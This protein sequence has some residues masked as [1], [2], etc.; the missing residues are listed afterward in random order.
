MDFDE[1]W[2]D[3][4]DGYSQQR[5]KNTSADAGSDTSNDPQSKKRKKKRTHTGNATEKSQMRNNQA[6]SK[7]KKN[8]SASLHVGSLN[9]RGRSGKHPEGPSGKWGEIN[10]TLKSHKIG[11]LAIQEAHLTSEA[12]SD[13]HEMYGRRVKIHYSQ[14]ENKRKAGVA[15][16]INKDLTPHKDVTE[17][18][19]IPGRALM[20]QIPWHA[21]LI[22]TILNVYA[23]NAPTENAQFWEELQSKFENDNIEKPDVLLGDFNVVEDAIDKLPCH[24]DASHTT[25]RSALL[26]LRNDWGLQDGWRTTYPTEKNYTFI[27]PNAR[28]R[29]DRI[30]TTK[31]IL[32]TATDWKIEPSEVGTDHDMVSVRVNNPAMPFIGMGR[33]V[34]PPYLLKDKTFK[35]QVVDLTEKLGQSLEQK[36]T[37]TEEINPQTIW[38]EYKE[39]IIKT[40]KKRDKEQTPKTV[41]RIAALRK[42]E[43]GILENDRL[44][45]QEKLAEVEILRARI[46][47]MVHK[48]HSKAR[49]ATKVRYQQSGEKIGKYWSSLSREAKPRDYMFSLRKPTTDANGEAQY[50]TRSDKMAELARENHKGLQTADIHPEETEREEAIAKTLERIKEESKI[51]DQERAFLADKVTEDQVKTALR[52]SASG[53]APGIVGIT[54]EFW[55]LLD[56]IKS[57]DKNG[58][59]P[60]LNIVKCL[61][62]VF[63]DIEEFGVEQNS[64]FAKGWMCPLYKK[65]DR[66]EISNYRPITLLNTDYKIYTKALATKLAEAIPNAIHP[67]QAGFM[68]GRKIQDQTQLAKLMVHYAE[69]TEQNGVIVALDQEK[70]YD[71]I[72]HDYLWRTLEAYNLPKA[73][74]TTV[75]SLYESA[76]TLVMINGVL[77]DPYKVTRGVRQGDPMSCLL[78]NLAIEPLA[79]WLRT[80]T[81]LKGFTIPGMSEKLITTLFADDTTVYLCE[82][83]DYEDLLKLLGLWCRASGAKFNKAKTEIIPIGTK[84][85]RKQLLDS[86]K[87]NPGRTEIDPSVHIAGEKEPTRILG[88]WIGNGIDNAAVWSKQM[89]KVDTALER[90]GRTRPTVFGRRLIVQMIVGGATQ[91]LT[92]VQGMPTEIEN[93]TQK[94]I[95]NFV[96]EGKKPSIGKHYLQAPPDQGGINLLNINARNEAI[97]LMWLKSYLNFSEERADWAI[98]ADILIEK[99]IAKSSKINKDLTINAYLQDWTPNTIKSAGLPECLR[100]MILTGKKYNVSFTA[101]HIPENEKTKLPAWY[102]LGSEKYRRGFQN[103]KAAKCLKDCHKARTVADLIA[104]T[105]RISQNNP[106]DFHQDTI[107]CNCIDCR[108]DKAEGCKAPNDCARAAEEM[109]AKLKTKWRPTEDTWNTD[110]LS[111]TPNRKKQNEEATKKDGEIIFDPSIRHG[112]DTTA[113]FR[114]FT[115]PEASCELP[116]KRTRGRAIAGE[117]IAYVAGDCITKDDG[118]AVTGGGIWIEDDHPEN[119]ALSLTSGPHSKRL[120]QIAAT[121]L[122]VQTTPETETLRIRTDSK[123][124]IDGITANLPKWEAMGYIGIENRKQ[125]KALA[126]ALRTRAAPTTFK[127]IRNENDAKMKKAKNLAKQG[128]RGEGAEL[129]ES[130]I[131]PRF[132]ITG[133]QMSIL[134]QSLAYK[135]ICEQAKLNEKKGLTTMLDMTRH[136][137]KETL[138]VLPND[139]TIW[140]SI[141][142]NDIPN[143]SRAFM[144]RTLHNAHKVGRYWE[145]IPDHEHRADCLFPD[146]QKATDDMT[147]ILVECK[148]PGAR[149]IWALAEKL[150]KLRNKEWPEITNVASILRCGLTAFK[151]GKTKRLE[152]NDRLYKI[153]MTESA[154]LIW[155][156]RCR[157]VCG[158]IKVEDWP[159][160]R[161]IHNMWLKKINERLTIDRAST[162]KKY[163]K[164][165]T[166]NTL[167]LKTWSGVLKEEHLLPDDWINWP[168]VLVGLDPLESRVAQDLPERQTARGQG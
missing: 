56:R 92:M 108:K 97:D 87:I 166:K 90:W 16:V 24:E 84:E 119:G 164:N 146:C 147:H 96:W 76:E 3:H 54:Y 100:R 101:L 93:E 141:K 11:V 145:K 137:A 85:Y 68:P 138:G 45:E 155:W 70:A 61:T 67:N 75:K 36:E 103:S 91:Y 38:K 55:K 71:K 40:A 126:A 5:T 99:S 113:F 140:N 37:R 163:G 95:A 124:L 39:K 26:K 104:L 72:C 168:G 114:V 79:N 134:T 156:L 65:G 22:V 125:I 62:K 13:L 161:Q 32:N 64:E 148:V 29:I 130:E 81:D 50:E 48:S 167:V 33:W 122:V 60:D 27:S 63:N 117:T 51:S 152:G 15:F 52:Q 77:S 53:T 31:K 73:F 18:E 34:I 30:Y 14:G 151:R 17:T 7:Q 154:A 8:T 133:A 59:H 58:K 150:W 123:Y 25:A 80:T 9:M 86:R 135:G 66:R 112:K 102:H 88:A 23:P 89:D 127:L 116:A 74:I 118:E 20:L 78:F 132:N 42:E 47:D 41:K 83:D 160:E 128:A 143:R 120:G 162:H 12:V 49:I 106:R 157:R 107:E 109:I 94:K 69:A 1:E 142:S 111:L 19:I 153:I 35:E 131:E 2:G 46:K 136:A 129:Q 43:R 158:E 44:T 144:Y 105:R 110:G 98:I 21:D 10:H 4:G 149:T 121:L 165:A 82:S 139:T 6:K 159:D 57:E 28:S 115:D